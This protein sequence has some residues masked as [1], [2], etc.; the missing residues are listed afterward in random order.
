MPFSFRTLAWK[1]KMDTMSDA[2]IVAI[3]LG[4][5]GIVAGFFSWLLILSYNLGQNK[6]KIDG[7]EKSNTAMGETLK[8]IFYRLDQLAAIVPHQC[9]QTQ[10]ITDM[11]IQIESISGI[12]RDHGGRM[13]RIQQGIR[14]VEQLHA[15]EKN[16]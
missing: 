6:A 13:D 15:R 14:D 12:L 9:G 11:R 10:T 3:V 5:V 1:W 7:F 4:A 16:E 2:V 8:R